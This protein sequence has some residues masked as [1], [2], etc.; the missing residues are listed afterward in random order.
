MFRATDVKGVSD[1]IAFKDGKAVFLE[2]KTAKGKQTRN[3]EQFQQD[4][5]RAGMLYK[6][7]RSVEEAVDACEWLLD[8]GTRLFLPC[9]E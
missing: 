3:Q 4:V 6:I 9:E 2:V 1:I 7:V 8:S 5:T